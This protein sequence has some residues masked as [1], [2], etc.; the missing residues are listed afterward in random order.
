MRGWEAESGPILRSSRALPARELDERS[1]GRAFF[2]P[3]GDWR[4]VQ[5]PNM[6]A[7][8]TLQVDEVGR[9]DGH[10][11]VFDRCAASRTRWIIRTI[12]LPALEAGSGHE[13]QF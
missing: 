5:S 4:D 3:V 8:V 10:L 1:I 12:Q 11:Y 9:A 6:F 7:T 13:H 2:L